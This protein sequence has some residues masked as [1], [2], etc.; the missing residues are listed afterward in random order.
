LFATDTRGPVR[1]KEGDRL[2]KKQA[3]DLKDIACLDILLA[4]E[5][6]G[7]RTSI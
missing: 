3:I 6:Y 4:L 5:A 1:D 2:T 7:V